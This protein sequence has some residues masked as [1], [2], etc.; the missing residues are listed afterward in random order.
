M[1]Q[2]LNIFFFVFHTVFILFVL[3]GWILRKTRTAHLAALTITALCWFGLGLFYGFGYCPCTDWHWRVRE[4]LG[5]YEMPRSYIKFLINVPTGWN[6]SDDL[7]D[8]VTVSIF[9]I[10]FAIAIAL[11]FLKRPAQ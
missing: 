2:F 7:V 6:P 1:Y 5:Y 11:R 3:F 10:V 8:I 4:H 9:F